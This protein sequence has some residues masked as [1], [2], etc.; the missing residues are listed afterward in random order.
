M[1]GTM[2][3]TVDQQ[4]KAIAARVRALTTAAIPPE[5]VHDRRR[6]ILT[7]QGWV[8]LGWDPARRRIHYW[9]V[10]HTATAEEEIPARELFLARRTFIVRGAYGFSE[11]HDNV[12]NS[13]AEWRG[14]V[15]GVMDGLRADQS[16]FNLPSNPPQNTPRGINLRSN[17]IALLQ[18][19]G[20]AHLTEME[21]V[22]EAT[23][24][25]GA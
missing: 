8:L 7:E 4:A 11:G 5:V 12:I 18:D 24:E 22:L 21:M 14:I 13:T 15:D 19:L 10:E 3:P 23:A 17:A 2:A 9:E 1:V 16:V 6:L 25:I 20:L